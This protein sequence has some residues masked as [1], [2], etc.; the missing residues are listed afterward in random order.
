MVR[1]KNKIIIYDKKTGFHVKTNY[2]KQK[3][4]DL[5]ILIDTKEKVKNKCKNHQKITIF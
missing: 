3:N 1:G 5:K 2:I 4:D